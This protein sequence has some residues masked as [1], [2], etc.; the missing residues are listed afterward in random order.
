[1]LT[2][3]LP[4]WPVQAWL[5]GLGFALLL[6]GLRGGWTDP[7]RPYWSVAAVLTASIV[8]AALAVWSRRQ[9]YVYVSGLL[10][11]LSAVL[12]RVAL[13]PASLLGCLVV[14][15]GAGVGPGFGGVV[16]N[17][18][19]ASTTA[20]CDRTRR[21]RVAVCPRRTGRGARELGYRR[22]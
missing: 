21:S 5:H 10:A 11:N 9:A 2:D 13:G 18:P 3:L 7:E 19:R 12:V 15:G 8:A 14:G 17:R 4:A 6:L 22:G 1:W 20:A 16:G